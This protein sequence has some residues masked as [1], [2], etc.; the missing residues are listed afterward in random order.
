MS[1]AVLREIEAE[2]ERQIDVC[3]YTIE[4]DDRLFTEMLMDAALA[5]ESHAMGE[6]VYKENGVPRGWPFKAE[7]WK[8]TEPRRDL[9]KAGALAIAEQERWLRDGMCQQALPD[10][11]LERCVTAISALDQLSAIAARRPTN[12]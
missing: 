1:E 11:V 4:H 6:A 10:M 8:P 9:V 3:G 7:A 12:S 2:R 5:Y